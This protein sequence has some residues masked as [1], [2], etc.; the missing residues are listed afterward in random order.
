MSKGVPQNVL[1]PEISTLLVNN[2]GLLILNSQTQGGDYIN[3]IEIY[4]NKD[5]FIQ[6]MVKKIINVIQC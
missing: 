5:G 3:N 4:A 1:Y 2:K 6:I